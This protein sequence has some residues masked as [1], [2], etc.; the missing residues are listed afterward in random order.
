MLRAKWCQNDS[1]KGIILR[2]AEILKIM[3]SLV[4]ELNFE[5]QRGS[6]RATTTGRCFETFQ[7][8]PPEASH[9]PSGH[10]SRFWHGGSLSVSST[11]SG[12]E[13]GKEGEKRDLTRLMTP[14]KGSAD[15]GDEMGPRRSVFTF[16]RWK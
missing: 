2:F 16:E 8:S 1:P 14:L 7:N 12:E 4:R 13:E 10:L 11:A 6:K 3:L 9:T 5:G 15:L